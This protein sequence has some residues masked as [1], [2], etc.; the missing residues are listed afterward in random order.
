MEEEVVPE[1]PKETASES[2]LVQEKGEPK[3][4]T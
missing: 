1:K 4:E 3:I 2:A